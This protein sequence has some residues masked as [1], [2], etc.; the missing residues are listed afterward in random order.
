M[1]VYDAANE[2]VIMSQRKLI[3]VYYNVD[4]NHWSNSRGDYSMPL[5]V[6]RFSLYEKI[7]LKLHLIHNGGGEVTNFTNANTFFHFLAVDSK[8]NRVI[9]TLSNNINSTEGKQLWEEANSANG[10][11]IIFIDCATEELKKALEGFTCKQFPIRLIV[12]GTSQEVIACYREKVYF[13]NLV[14][15]GE[16]ITGIITS[17]TIVSGDI[18]VQ[19]PAFFQEL[20]FDVN[21]FAVLAAIL[22]TPVGTDNAYF[23]T[24]IEPTETGAKVYFNATMQ[25]EGYALGY[26]LIRKGH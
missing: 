20:V 3:E 5:D 12:Y 8:G 7:A 13:D 23:V 22:R 15:E 11:F 17:S 21:C 1:F 18:V 9:E 14:I 25:E 24:N 10:R 26:S 4:G 6:P 19:P 2:R 16:E